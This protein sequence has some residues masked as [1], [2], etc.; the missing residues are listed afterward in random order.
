V[1]VLFLSYAQEDEEAAGIIAGWLTGH[2]HDVFDWQRPEHRGRRFVKQIQAAIG[3]ADMFVVLLS[4]D[5]MISHWCQ[6][7]Y[8]LAIHREK[9]LQAADPGASFIYVLKVREVDLAGAGFLRTYDQWDLTNLEQDMDRKL[10]NLP[11]QP[12]SAPQAG[13]GAGCAEPD[14]PS[15][16]PGSASSLFRNRDDEL[17]L[18]MHGLANRAG[19]HFWLVVGPP[20]LGKTWF[21]KHLSD[22]LPS[23]NGQI[24]LPWTTSLMDVKNQETESRDNP[25]ALLAELFGLPF[26]TADGHVEDHVIVAQ[27]IKNKAPY[28]AIIDSTELL[29][30]PTVIALR[31]RFGRILRGIREAGAGAPFALVVAS[32]RGDYWR[33]VTHGPRLD[34]LPLTEFKI[35]VVERALRDLADEME[36]TFSTDENRRNALRVHHL[37][38]GLPA[39]L[40]RCLC[41]IRDEEWVGIERLEG[42][43]LFEELAEPYIQDDL[44][45]GSSLFPSSGGMPPASHHGDDPDLASDALVSAFRMLAPYRLF[46]QSHLRHHVEQDHDFAAKLAA[47]EWSLEQLWH[48]ISATALLAKPLDEPWQEMHAAIRRL[49][50]R[51]NF[52]TRDARVAAHQEARAF[53]EIWADNQSGKEQVIALLEYLWHEAML[54]GL[55]APAEMEAT[56]TESAVKLTR[57]LHASAAYSTDE[58]RHFGAEHLQNDV[59]FQQA[60]SNVDGLFATLV[61]TIAPW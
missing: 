21:L 30:K 37:S 51:Y 7:E 49:L 36:R 8:E 42:Q 59:E 13:P 15:A 28:L 22:E 6:R 9:D 17:D 20:Q 23:Q 29:S 61:A 32:R 34:M 2:D 58:L 55:T 1:P 41:W 33:G 35:E 5:Y 48:A 44:L 4:P 19:Q 47:L 38:E 10:G 26:A 43:D 25:G 57:A 31:D 16:A 54:L 46:T 45:S 27:I 14:T 40:A 56:L 53:V 50:Y 24:Q 12:S 3:A 60:V 39:L 11:E 52:K 18:V